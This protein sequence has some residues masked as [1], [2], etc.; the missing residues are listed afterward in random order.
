MLQDGATTS[1]SCPEMSW[2]PAPDPNLPLP[3]AEGSRSEGSRS[4]GVGAG[5]KRPSPGG[6]QEVGE[7]AEE[8]KEPSPEG[9]SPEPQL[10]VPEQAPLSHQTSLTRHKFKH[11]TK[12]FK[13]EKSGH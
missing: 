2:A 11:K 4:S 1:V 9:W 6:S 7:Q 13:T 12:D 8:R 10:P 3:G 5:S